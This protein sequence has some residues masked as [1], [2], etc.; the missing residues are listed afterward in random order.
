MVIKRNTADSVTVCCN[1]TGDLDVLKE[2]SYTI[3]FCKVCLHMYV[4]TCNIS[5]HTN[6]CVMLSVYLATI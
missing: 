4:H 2:N 6:E 1:E 3:W 5:K